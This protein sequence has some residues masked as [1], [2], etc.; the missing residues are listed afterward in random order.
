MNKDA[1]NRLANFLEGGNYGFDMGDA[2]ARPHCGT[3]G[4]IGG[5][6]AVLWPEIQIKT[7]DPEEDDAGGFTWDEHK[8]AEKLG[9][10]YEMQ[11]ELCYP[12]KQ[13]WPTNYGQV[14]RA[15]AVAALRRLAE[16]GKVEFLKEESE[17]AT[18]V[19]VPP[20]DV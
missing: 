5:H 6:A 13:P 4:C 10:T 7:G 11:D 18:D 17:T 2:Y 8:L 16:T 9:I 15:G 19:P 3:A 1:I 14:T 12:V 20:T